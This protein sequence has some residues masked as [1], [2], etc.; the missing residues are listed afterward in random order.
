MN[1]R[2][3]L[4]TLGY[5]LLLEAI[6]LLFP[7]AVAFYY[8]EK[9]VPYLIPIFSL[10]FLGGCFITIKNKKKTYYAKEGFLITALSWVLLSVF[11]A[12]PFVLDGAI[13]SYV[14]AFFETVSGFT[15][16][17]SS[18]LSDVESLSYGLLFWR[19]FTHWIGGMGILVFALAILPL[20]KDNSMHV[21]KAESPGPFTS[22]LFPKIKDTAKWLYCIYLFLT[23]L[24]IILLRLGGMPLFDSVVTSFGT[25]GTGGFG[26]K[27]SS[28]AF[29][30]SA[31][32]EYVI[33]T[34]MLLFGINFNVFFLFVMRK[35][36][37]AL[38]NEEM[39]SYF[40]IALVSV[41]LIMINILSYCKNCEEAFRF[42]FFQVSS[43]ITTTGYST[44][45]FNL[46]PSFSKLILFLLM[47][48]GACG[49]STAGG[50]KI[51]RM[52]ILFKKIRNDLLSLVHPKTVRTIKFE[53]KKVEDR[54]VKEVGFYFV[55]YFFIIGG[56]TLLVSLDNFDFETTLTS[57]VSCI[58]NIGPGFGLTG[59]V[60]NFS[61]FSNFSKLLLSL[62]M[63]LGRLELYPM[64]LLLSPR[65]FEKK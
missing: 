50:L 21:M 43:I 9:I 59:P 38:L 18:I 44:T 17:G 53:G 25:A 41:F 58:S 51:S 12:L 35:W 11:G 32:L 30:H 2:F 4:K 26:I 33:A 22:K 1:Y 10:V 61:I 45:D 5:I 15:T 39:R 47:I 24:E 64:L 46:W 63:L 62:A 42:A 49:G 65:I 36:K 20:S 55:L 56:I 37:Q 29:Y 3:I 8:H 27:N 34:F 13:G 7:M 57:V 48:F 16:T 19:S 23:I 52:L 14:D 6:L 40:I 31:Y 28:I 60:G 54:V